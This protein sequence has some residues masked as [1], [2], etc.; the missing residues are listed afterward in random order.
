MTTQ[1]Q[2]SRADL[3]NL[4]MNQVFK[5]ENTED[6]KAKATA[7][8]NKLKLDARA[9]SEQRRNVA[10]RAV[11]EK[12][13]LAKL[14]L[15]PTN[16]KVRKAANTVHTRLKRLGLP[17]SVFS[18]GAGFHVVIYRASEWQE[19]TKDRSNIEIGRYESKPNKQLLAEDIERFYT[20][21]ELD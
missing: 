8:L 12:K 1:L 19:L 9:R 5:K 13:K 11:A 18:N 10:R 3:L 21:S 15:L 16:E 7:K 4:S 17:G 20:G 14:A 2:S 6:S